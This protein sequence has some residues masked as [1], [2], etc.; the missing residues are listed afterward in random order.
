MIEIGHLEVQFDV[1]V[2]DRELFEA[3]FATNITRWDAE[4]RLAERDARQLARES[5]VGDA[6]GDLGEVL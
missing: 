6:L 2:N 3:L 1:K 5:A 4:R